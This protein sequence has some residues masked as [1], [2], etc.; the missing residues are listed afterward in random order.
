MPIEIPSDGLDLL[1]MQDAGRAVDAAAARIRAEALRGRM[2]AELS[3]LPLPLRQAMDALI[4]EIG[5]IGAEAEA[6]R[7]A[8]M[9]TRRERGEWLQIDPLRHMPEDRGAA[10]PPPAAH[11]EIHAA[12]PDFT[13]FGWHSPEGRGR[14]SWRW[15]G[16][17]PAASVVIPDLGPGTV[18]LELDLELPFRAPF[19]GNSVLVL[20][21]GEPLDLSLARQ[22][23][24]RATLTG[25][26]DG[27]EAPGANLGLV[28]LGPLVSDPTGRDTRRL[29][30]GIWRVAA[31]RLD[32]GS[33]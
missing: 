1:A 12:D 10:P 24:S 25:L 20:A 17:A 30:V 6:A 14:E 9:E 22:D 11:Y 2:A 32:S 16:I 15:S 18:A 28:F 33:P 23:G 29:G 19:A 21:N 7:Q 26:W 31:R 5:R 13:G 27:A 8:A 3:A 4:D